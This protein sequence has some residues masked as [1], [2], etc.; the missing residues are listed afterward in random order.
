MKID[1]VVEKVE[2]KLMELEKTVEAPIKALIG[3]VKKHKKLIVILALGYL[4]VHFLFNE[5]SE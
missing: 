5:D 1:A 3:F 4:V 2:G